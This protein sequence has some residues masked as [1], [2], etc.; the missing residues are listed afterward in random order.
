[1]Q[2]WIGW[3]RR[4]GWENEKAPAEGLAANCGGAITA[5][6]ELQ[7]R[8]LPADGRNRLKQR[9]LRYCEL[10]TLAMV[11]CMKPM[12]EWIASGAVREHVMARRRS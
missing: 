7:Q 1:M 3:W 4:C 9:L 12:Q 5:Y 2:G 6:A 8:D 11:I 10:D